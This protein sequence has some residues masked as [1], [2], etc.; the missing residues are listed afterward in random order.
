[1]KKL[2]VASVILSVLVF[3]GA[4]LA[5][6][7]QPSA[8]ATAK[9]G[10]INVLDQTDLPQTLILSQILKTA[11]QKDLFIDV[12]L[13]CGLYT[14]TK[15]GKAGTVDT[16]IAKGGVYVT[17]YVDDLPAY[18]GEVKFCERQQTLTTYLQGILDLGS[19]LVVADEYVELILET[20][21]ANS[22]NFIMADLSAGVHTI[23]VKARIDTD[24][25]GVAEA[26]GSIG[27]GSVTVESVR[28]IRNE[29][30]NLD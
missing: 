3:F 16:S 6:E 7:N 28:M 19:G 14:K 26:K 30:F 8:K 27:K 1:M 15:S 2:V 13:E 11:S 24:V 4:A 25:S 5:A 22:F 17:V 23:K 12:S 18:P 10:N 20:M 21:D 9:V 29:D